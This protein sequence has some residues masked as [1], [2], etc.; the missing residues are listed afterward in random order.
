MARRVCEEC[1]NRPLQMCRVM[2]GGFLFLALMPFILAAWSLF[3]LGEYR[4]PPPEYYVPQVAVVCVALL[5]GYPFPARI[6]DNATTIIW[7]KVGSKINDAYLPRQPEVENISKR[8][9]DP[10]EPLRNLI[11]ERRPSHLAGYYGAHDILRGLRNLP[12][13]LRPSHLDRISFAGQYS[14]NSK[15]YV[16]PIW[17]HQELWKTTPRAGTTQPVRPLNLDDL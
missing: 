9:S 6:R 16:G 10:L 7:N 2:A 3:S 4:N 8:A 1:L 14:S 11:G 12:S 17:P 5:P 13:E 15:E